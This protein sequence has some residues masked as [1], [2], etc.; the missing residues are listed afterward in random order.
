MHADFRPN[1]VHHE[2]PL[3]ETFVQGPV[4]HNDLH[5]GASLAHLVLYLTHQIP[6][7]GTEPERAPL[8]AHNAS[9]HQE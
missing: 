5:A 9:S 3:T 2:S 8:K 4:W 1:A 6:R 7:S